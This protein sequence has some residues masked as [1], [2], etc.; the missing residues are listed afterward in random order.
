MIQSLIPADIGARWISTISR[1]QIQVMCSE[2]DH[3]GRQLTGNVTQRAGST[4]RI[5]VAV[6]EEDPRVALQLAVS[7]PAKETESELIIGH[8]PVCI[9]TKCVVGA[10]VERRVVEHVLDA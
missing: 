3:T 8:N 2:L 1:P 10:V 7:S 9:I 4:P 5:Q 6:S